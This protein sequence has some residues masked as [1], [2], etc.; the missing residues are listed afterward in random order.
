MVTVPGILRELYNS[1]IHALCSSN[2]P[3]CEDEGSHDWSYLPH[4]KQSCCMNIV[5]TFSVHEIITPKAIHNNA[6]NSPKT[7][8]FL[9][10]ISCLR[11]DLNPQHSNVHMIWGWPTYY[12]S[13]ELGSVWCCFAYIGKHV[14]ILNNLSWP[15]EDVLKFDVNKPDTEPRSPDEGIR[16]QTFVW[17]LWLSVWCAGLLVI[18]PGFD[19]GRKFVFLIPSWLLWP[20]FVDIKL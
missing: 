3:G 15:G 17:W 6:A 11:R 2:G 12:V 20:M 14:L 7:V 18:R 8:I 1:I 19:S 16:G 10:K 5:S 13:L 9:R 4:C